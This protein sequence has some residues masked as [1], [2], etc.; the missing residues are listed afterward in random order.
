M[1][2]LAQPTRMTVFAALAKHR[3]DGLPVGELAKLVDTPANTMSAH[4]AILA[5]AGA[6]VASRAGR[7][8]TYTIAPEVLRDLTLFLVGQCAGGRD[9]ISSEL[10]EELNRACE[11]KSA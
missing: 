2:A 1:S 9:L 5:R 4:L 6:V 7:V 10:V 3:P 11:V 8:V